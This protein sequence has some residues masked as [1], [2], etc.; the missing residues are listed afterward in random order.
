MTGTG[1]DALCSQSK[2]GYRP[3]VEVRVD[4]LWLVCLSV[5]PKTLAVVSTKAGGSYLTL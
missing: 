2:F 3:G 4:L 1:E 5:S